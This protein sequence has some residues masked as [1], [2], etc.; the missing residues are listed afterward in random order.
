MQNDNSMPEAT[1]T[2]RQVLLTLG[3]TAGAL[4]IGTGVS[5]LGRPAAAA[6]TDAAAGANPGLTKHGLVADELQRWQ[7]SHAN[8]GV[9]VDADHFYGIGNHALVKHRKDTGALVGEWMGPRDGAIIHLNA[10]WVDG[11][12]LVV[13]HSNFP[14]LPMASS[15][16][17][18]DRNS[19]QPVATYSLGI[20]LGSLTWAVRH[21]GFWW[22]CFANYNDNGTTPGFDQRWTHVGKFDDN[23]QMLESWL[24]PPQ[25]VATWGDSACSGGDWGDDGLLYVTGHDAA[26]L[27]VVRL[28]QQG[29][30]LEYVTTIDVP[31]EGQSWAWDRSAR[32]ERIIYGI[33]R[34]R[35]E[36]IV[37]RIPELPSTLLG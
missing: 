8:Q 3:A 26:E 37:A 18:Y 31:F 10:G 30:T 34:A 22:A 29:V 33:S 16:E 28:P 27:Y 1:V 25:I 9:A 17:T 11:D 14:Q 19:L 23:W 36:V 35:R 12:E 4:A 5:S 6:S 21:Q 7:I 32:G 2:R 20:R 13:A 24:F 15:L